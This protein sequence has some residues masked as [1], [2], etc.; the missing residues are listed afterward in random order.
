ML[1]V[2]ASLIEALDSQEERAHADRGKDERGQGAGELEGTGSRDPAG[3]DDAHALAHGHLVGDVDGI[4]DQGDRHLRIGQRR[5]E[6]DLARHLSGRGAAVETD[7]VARV[8]QSGRRL[9]DTGLL[10]GHLGGA[11]AQRRLGGGGVGNGAAAGTAD[12]LLVRQM[13][14]V[15]SCGRCRDPQP[16]DDVVDMDA[17]LVHDDVED[18]RMPIMPRHL[19]PPEGQ[20]CG[21]GRRE[22]GLGR[23]VYVI[24]ASTTCRILVTVRQ[25]VVVWTSA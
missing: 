3:D 17:A 4:G 2:G 21:A 12:Q 7:G 22:Y 20:G 8:H 6:R 14:E 5:Q 10:I 24:C 23:G 16:R 9:G 15:A 25:V 13:V 19:D 18:G 11:V 1:G